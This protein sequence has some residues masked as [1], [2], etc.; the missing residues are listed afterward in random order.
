MMAKKENFC[1]GCF[2]WQGGYE[3]NRCCNYIFFAN[4]MRPFDPGEGCTVKIELKVTR[5]RR[6]RVKE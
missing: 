5:K 3:V 4:K 1:E 2:Y 6:R